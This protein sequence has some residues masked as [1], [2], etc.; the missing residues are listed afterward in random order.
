M[1]IARP[2]DDE[3]ASIA[4]LR[5]LE[6]LDSEPE[7]EFEAIVRAA[8]VVCGAPISAISLIDVDR[9]WFKAITGLPGV[10]ETPREIAFCAHV[11]RQD[12]YFE[13]PDATLDARFADNPLVAG[14][15]DIRFYAGAPVKLRDGT[16]VGSM[17]VI[18][19]QPR[20]LDDKQ[21]EVLICLADAAARALEG[22]RAVIAMR[23]VAAEAAQ[24]ALVLEHSADAIIGVSI[25]GRVALWNRSAEL[26]FGHAATDIVGQTI[27]RLVPTERSHEERNVR[28][29]V[30]DGQAHSYETVRLHRDGRRIDVAV[31][32]VP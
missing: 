7:A 29:R 9:Q 30:A 21:R 12:G 19:R 32:A 23:R 13:V 3:S 28:A 5:D 16:R 18:D 24:A 26:P 8:S 27:D 22:R 25:D 17:C 4:A 15:P 20:R 14:A 1:E 11:V 6:V 2:R 10:T 31:T